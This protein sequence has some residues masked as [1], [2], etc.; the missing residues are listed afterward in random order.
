MKKV[1]GIYELWCAKVGVQ[2]SPTE[3]HGALAM[4]IYLKERGLLK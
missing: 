2:F 1:W 4:L 3:R